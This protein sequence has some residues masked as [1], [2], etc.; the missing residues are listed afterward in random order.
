MQARGLAV[1]GLQVVLSGGLTLR[2]QRL[3]R[4]R[5]VCATRTPHSG[6]HG[7]GET[8]DFFEGWYNRITLEDARTSVA[9]IYAVFDPG[10]RTRRTGVEA[11]VLVAGPGGANAT[12]AT[13]TDCSRFAAARRPEP[14]L[15]PTPAAPSAR[16]IARGA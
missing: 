8:G 13:S 7:Q 9:L 6:Y 5:A 15:R 12:H 2:S 14:F 16:A 10:A 1:V 3:L 4:G 11:Q